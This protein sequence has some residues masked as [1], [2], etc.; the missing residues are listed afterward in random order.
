VY[1]WHPHPVGGAGLVE[2][3][4]SI[5]SPDGNQDD[6]W[7]I[8]RRQ[9]GG[10][11]KRYVEWL[12]EGHAEGD[13]I[14]DAWYVD[15]GAAYE[16][17]D[18]SSV[19]GLDYLEGQTV[20]V[21]ADGSPQPQKVV[22]LGAIDVDPPAGKVIVGLPYRSVIGTM[23]R[24]E[25]SANGTAQGKLKNVNEIVVRFRETVGAKVGPSESKLDPVL[26]R[27][28]SMPMTGPIPP[29]TGDKIV[30]YPGDWERDGRVYVVRDQ[31][32]PMTVVAIMPRLTTND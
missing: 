23:R 8:V 6:L 24:D 28:T 31:P 29:F 10:A 11:D 4:V 2:S 16:G 17:P 13:D 30:P 5:P 32:L 25:G 1:G 20:D 22:V 26:F 9:I 3:V 18:V 21:L 27:D 15:C 19:S 12:D 7:M 14:I